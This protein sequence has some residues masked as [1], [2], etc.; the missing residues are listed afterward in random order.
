MKQSPSVNQIG[1][2]LAHF[3]K[4]YHLAIFSLTVV[5]GVSA[6]MFLLNN[7]IVA[8]NSEK[9]VSP[10]STAIFDTE[11]IEKVDNFST[12]GENQEFNLPPGRTNPFVE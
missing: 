8:S 3:M 9:P 2:T 11:T 1:P 6:A 10:N 5:V 7:L 12:S 4:R